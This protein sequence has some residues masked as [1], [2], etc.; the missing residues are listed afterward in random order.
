MKVTRLY[1]GSDQQSHFEDIEITLND[2]GEIGKLS[3]LE[4]AS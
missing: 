4:S 3:E 1:T 2:H